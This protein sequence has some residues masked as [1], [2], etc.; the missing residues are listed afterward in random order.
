M[1]AGGD[2]RPRPVRRQPS[3]EPDVVLRLARLAPGEGE[4]ARQDRARVLSAP[5]RQR[6]ESFLRPADRDE[7]VLAHWLVRHTLSEGTSVPPEDWDFAQGR[8]G[9]PRIAERFGDVREFSLSHSAGVCLVALS[10]GRP[11]GVD[12][13]RLAGG[14]ANSPPLLRSCLS[15]AELATLSA[16]PDEEQHP[17]F[18]QLWALKEAL[19]KAMGLGLRLPFRDVDFTWRDGEPV[20]RPT[21]A[22]PEPERWTCHHLDAPA[23][24][25]AALCVRGPR[26]AAVPIRGVRAR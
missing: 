22:V 12:I 24:L 3:P 17:A 10:T 20:L 7:Y 9:K 16:L 26:P 25:R 5:E 14:T 15:G 11:V 13:E 18:I 4:G 6:A 8:Y 2:I 1:I 21:T 23:G 19:A